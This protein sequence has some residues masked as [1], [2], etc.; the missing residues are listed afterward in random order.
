M[1]TI[2]WNLFSPSL[3][4]ENSD[5]INLRPGF[6]ETGWKMFRQRSESMEQSPQD[7]QRFLK[8]IKRRRELQKIQQIQ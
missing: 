4:D 8:V 3:A 5:F 7:L 2:M 1:L 6:N